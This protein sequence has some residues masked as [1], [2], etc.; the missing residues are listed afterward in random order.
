MK[1]RWRVLAE[2][3]TLRIALWAN[4][5]TL[6]MFLGV[7]LFG[8]AASLVALFALL[9]VWCIAGGGVLCGYLAVFVDASH[10]R[11]LAALGGAILCALPLPLFYFLLNVFHIVPKFL[12]DD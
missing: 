5:L 6:L 1:K 3:A 2:S 10:R 12:F 8:R 11:Y 4:G 9:P 7:L